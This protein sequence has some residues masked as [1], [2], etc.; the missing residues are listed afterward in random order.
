[1]TWDVDPDSASEP[2]STQVTPGSRLSVWPTDEVFENYVCWRKTCD[3]V[4]I[5]YARWENSERHDSGIAFAAY[6]A[7]LDRE[8]CAARFHADCL[9]HLRSL[10]R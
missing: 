7:A 9:E 2:V 8:E 4:R 3:E 5:A 10:A 6:C 1:M